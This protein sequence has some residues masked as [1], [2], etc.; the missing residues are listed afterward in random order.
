M[1]LGAL[2]FLCADFELPLVW[3]GLVAVI[4]IRE[5]QGLF[6]VA[7]HVA[8]HASHLSVLAKQRVFCF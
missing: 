8:G 5:R 4:A 7:I 2:T 3:V 6:E 1:A